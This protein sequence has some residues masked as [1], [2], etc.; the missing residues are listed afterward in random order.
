MSAEL[1][2]KL[3]SLARS[4][5]VSALEEVINAGVDLNSLDKFG[6]TAIHAAYLWRH[7]DIETKKV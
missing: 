7:Y 1:G 3:F 5:K 4:G 2:K 6:Q